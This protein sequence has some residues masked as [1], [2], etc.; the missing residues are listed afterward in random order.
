[1][2][3]QRIESPIPGLSVP[4]EENLFSWLPLSFLIIS[5]MRV[6]VFLTLSQV[7]GTV[8]MKNSLSCIVTHYCESKTL[9]S[10]TVR[11]SQKIG[12]KMEP[13][14]GDTA[15]SLGAGSGVGEDQIASAGRIEEQKSRTSGRGYAMLKGTWYSGCSYKGSS[16]GLNQ[17]LRTTEVWEEGKGPWLFM[18]GSDWSWFFSFI[19]WFFAPFGFKK[20]C[21]HD[22]P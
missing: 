10:S 8:G 11:N 6:P 21:P 1:M 13:E 12:E 3:Y 19:F 2:G 18:Q 16:G 5:K 4:L 22:F 9:Q 15:H 7:R 17:G 20:S 14:K